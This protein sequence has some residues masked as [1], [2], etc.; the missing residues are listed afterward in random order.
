MA[1][2][3]SRHHRVLIVGGG[4][5]GLTVAHLLLRL[6]P[7]LDLALL[8]SSADH[9]YQPG[10]TLV[11]GGL[12]SLEQTRRD[13]ASL[14]P[15]GCLWIQAA[16]TEFK[17]AQNQLLIS[18]GETLS[19]DVLIIATGLRCRWEQIKGLP[20]ALGSHGICSNYSPQYASYSWETI[21]N[22]QGGTAIF[23]VPETAIKCGGAPQ[24]VMYM[25]DDHFKAKSG[26]GVN[27]E[28]LFCTA[29]STMFAV[30]AYGRVMAQLALRRGIKLLLRHKLIEVL[31]EQQLAVF[32]VSDQAGNVSRKEFGFD[33]LH[34]VPPMTAPDVVANSPLASA[35]AGGWVD[36]DKFSTQHRRYANVFALGDVASLP[37]AKTAGSARAAAP[38]TA[39]NVLAFL[40]GQPLLAQYDGY[41][42]CPI[43]S[44]YGRVV[45]AEF[46]YSKQP[47]SSFLVDPTKER[48]SMWLLKTRLL[49]WLY[50]QRMLKGLP[51]EGRYL[52][53][54]APLV[55]WLR[56]DYR[57][58]P[59]DLEPQAETSEGCS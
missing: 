59:Q 28:V 1:K 44:G 8:E 17:P 40:G 2:P 13:Q 22:F 27:T 54:L 18:T 10:W 9:Y 5:A 42:V 45:M 19:Y 50:W 49:P 16:A 14:I 53:P 43:I 52:K 26:V 25:A 41:S 56:L 35:E 24:K 30:P 51:H 29:G 33:M 20:Q 12:C 4:A 48:W 21:R 55:H 58:N 47:V 11:G 15:K 46:D 31:A 34:V 6:Q 7:Q 23:T 36:V 57:A 37:T 39:A 32:A 38:V 3:G